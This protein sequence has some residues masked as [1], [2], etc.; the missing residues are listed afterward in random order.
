MAVEKDAIVG[1]AKARHIEYAKHLENLYIIVKTPKNIKSKIIKIKD[2][3]FIYPT[4]SLNKYLFLYD[5][6]SL[7]LRIC[8]ENRI[9]FIATQDPFITGLIG[10]LLKK[11]YKIPL[12]IQVH[13][14]MID[15]KYFIKENVFNFFLNK[16]AKLIIG[17][18]DTIRVVTLRQR[19]RPTL[20]G[21]DKEKIHYVPSFIDFSLFSQRNDNSVRKLNLNSRFDKIVL[22]VS[23]LAKE[24]SIETLIRAIPYVIEDYPRCLFL[25]IGGGPE[26]KY[27][28]GLAS[29]LGVKEFIKFQGPVSY[30]DI[31][32]YFQAADIFISTSHYEGTCMSIHEAAVAK[33]PIISTPHAGA[34]DALKNGHTGFIV[35]FDDYLGLSKNILYLLEND[36]IAKDMGS[37][38]HTFIIEHFKKEDILKRY[39]HLWEQTKGC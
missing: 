14:D 17:K 6:Y 1:N 23:R 25:I 2:N 22:S 8:K 10:W 37:N 28:E 3:L 27:L 11:K 26:E 15:N 29:Q 7:G 36:N 9:D 38:A 5:A 31:P 21:I 39:C 35:N 12:N 20:K 24:K 16:L 18:A 13:G 30:K 4:A 19:E 32:S 33:K 34:Y